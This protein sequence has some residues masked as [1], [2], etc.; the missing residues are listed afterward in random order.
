[1][2]IDLKGS[3]N[4]KKAKHN[5]LTSVTL[6]RTID[7]PQKRVVIAH[8]EEIQGGIVL[9][10]NDDYDI[11]GDWTQAQAVGQ[12]VKIITKSN[13]IKEA[14]APDTQQL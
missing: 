7:D 4:V 5:P 1:M 9:W 2:V 6:L 13:V 11:M 3:Y 10:K 14:P 12:L 8:V